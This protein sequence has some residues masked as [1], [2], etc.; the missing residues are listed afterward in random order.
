MK[1]G[2]NTLVHNQTLSEFWIPVLKPETD[3]KSNLCISLLLLPFVLLLVF[4]ACNKSDHSDDDSTDNLNNTNTFT[5]TTNTLCPNAPNYGDSILYLQPKSSGDYTVSPINN[6]GIQ[7]KY[8]SW[9][10]GLDIDPAT[11]TIDLSNSETGVRYK[12]GFVKKNTTDTCVSMLILGGLTYMDSIYVLDKNDTLALPVFNANPYG[13]SVCDVSDDSDYPDSTNAGGNNKCAFD[14]DVNGQKAND[15]KLRVRTKS[16]IINLKK[17]FADGLFGKN[18]KNG[19]NKK[20]KIVYQLND[21]SRKAKQK[22]N[23]QMVYYEK[24]SDIPTAVKNEVTGKRRNM[25]QF[26]IVNGKP[27][28]PLLIIAGLSY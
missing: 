6:T 24:V 19:D 26:Q 12:I 1:Y 16:G 20:I 22:I 2:E 27:R 21:N 7:G 18:P 3:M 10:E 15:Q 13:N 25:N 11:G 17:S 14:D 28:P 4:V 5:T 9:P 23:V 8:L